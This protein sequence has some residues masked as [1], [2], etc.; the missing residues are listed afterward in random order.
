MSTNKNILIIDD[1]MHLASTL[2]AGLEAHGYSTVTAADAAIGWKLAHAHL[3]DLILCDIDLPGKDGRRLLQEMRADTAL[4]DR[5]LVL[6]TGKADYANPRAT[7]DLGADDFLLKP[8]PLSSLLACVAARLQ[9]AEL[10]RRLD[11]RAVAQLND[12]LHANLP[13]QFFDPLAGVL[14]LTELL[15]SEFPKLSEDEIRQDLRD[16]HDAARRLHRSLRNYLLILELEAAEA[17]R[18]SELLAP[19][20]VV[21]ALTD[22]AH[23]AG[24]RHR[25]TADLVVEL[26]GVPLQANAKDLTLI[27]EEMVDNALAFSRRGTPVRVRLAVA[28]SQL[29]FSVSDAGRGLTSLQLQDLRSEHRLG[30]KGGDKTGTG[31]GLTVVGLL[32]RQLGGKL[33]LDSE[34]GRGTTSQLVLPV[35]A[36]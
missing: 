13:R 10:S 22:G 27:A 12:R 3:P 26:N 7:M 30:A 4:A 19:D 17:M 5:Q 21:A 25:R 36:V 18:W 35:G 20:Q 34:A 1:D 2:A 32:A 14:G 9:R 11:D 16:I 29:V 23:A 33:L 28:G 6:M 31:L 24:E 15:Q 8:F